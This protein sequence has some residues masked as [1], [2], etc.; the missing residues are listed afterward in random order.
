MKSISMRAVIAALVVLVAA[1]GCS[2]QA[3]AT[4]VISKRK[5]ATPWS[6][7]SAPETTVRRALLPN[8]LTVEDWGTP[9]LFKKKSRFVVVELTTA[10]SIDELYP[11]LTREVEE[12]GYEIAFT[13]TEGFEAEIFFMVPPDGLGSIKVA[14]G[15]CPDA[16]MISFFFQ[17][18]GLA[19]E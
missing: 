4:E 6:G 13:E 15:L 9:R 11:R 8:G 14:D 2:Q 16:V 19:T 18:R 10:V 12:A 3:P 17:P 7:C 1:A 5:A